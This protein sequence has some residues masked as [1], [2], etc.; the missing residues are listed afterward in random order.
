MWLLAGPLTYALSLSHFYPPLICT[1]VSLFF[2]N[3]G[4]GGIHSSV[5]LNGV[6]CVE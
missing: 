6:K 1:C 3:S 4:V 5:Y 2:G